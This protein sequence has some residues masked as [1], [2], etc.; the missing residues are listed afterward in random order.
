MLTQVDAARVSIILNEV[1]VG[2]RY[3]YRIGTAPT[4]LRTADAETHNKR[5]RHPAGQRAR[6]AQWV[7]PSTS[8]RYLTYGGGGSETSL[9]I[10]ELAA[11]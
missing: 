5:K 11:R 9:P 3:G 8:P 10:G 2:G 7:R 1:E 4:A 6:A